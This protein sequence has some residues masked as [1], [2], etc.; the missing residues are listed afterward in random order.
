MLYRTDQ[1]LQTKNTTYARIV[2]TADL[3]RLANITFRYSRH[4]LVRILV[5][6]C[7]NVNSYV[8]QETMI[9]ASFSLVY[10]NVVRT[11]PK[12]LGNN[13]ISGYISDSNHTTQ[14][15]RKLYSHSEITTATTRLS[16]YCYLR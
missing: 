5:S 11:R 16:I 9:Y 6:S 3:T 2:P 7:G 15:Q 12:P 4:R 1:K 13:T 14:T 8:Y 10:T